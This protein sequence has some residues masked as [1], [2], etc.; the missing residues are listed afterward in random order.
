MASLSD[1]AKEKRNC[2]GNLSYKE[3]CPFYKGHI[4]THTDDNCIL[5]QLARD[6]AAI[7]ITK[8]CAQNP[9]GSPG[10]VADK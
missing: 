5:K 6:S 3:I 9:A 10:Y 1:Q 7:V 8:M 2:P 4:Y